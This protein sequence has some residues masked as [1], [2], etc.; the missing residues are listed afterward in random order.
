MPGEPR[1]EALRAV[2]LAPGPGLRAVHITAAL[3]VVGCFPEKRF[4]V[5]SQSAGVLRQSLIVRDALSLE[6]LDSDLA[7]PILA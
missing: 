4:R 2:A 3:P 6:L 1:L 5:G 7:L